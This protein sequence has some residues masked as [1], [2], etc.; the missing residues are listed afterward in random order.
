[1]GELKP[2]GSEKLAGDAKLRRILELTYYNSSDDTVKPSE[3]IKESTT[4]VYGIVKEKDGYYVK[5]GLD[6]NSLDYIGGLYMK[7]KNKFPS[8]GEALKKC[9]FLIEQENLQEATK[10]ILKQPKPVSQAEAPAPVPT[11]ELPPPPAAPEGDVPPPA[12]EDNLPPLPDETSDETP[13][14][15]VQNYLKIIQKMTGKLTQKLSTYQDKLE[16]KDI[17]YVLNMVLAAVDLDKL[18]ETDKEEILSKLE[19]EEDEGEESPD[20]GVPNDQTPIPAEEGEM[21]EADGVPAIAGSSVVDG[22]S[23][24][25]ELINNPFDDDDFT[26][27]DDDDEDE[28]FT[29]GPEDYKAA[30]AAHHDIEKES[31]VKLDDEGNVVSDDEIDI[32]SE[33]KSPEDDDE[34]VDEFMSGESVEPS[35]EEEK[36]KELD[37]DELTNA[38]NGSVRETLGKY[39]SE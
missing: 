28:T 36:V 31:G 26:P 23:A 12:P 27:S 21:E 37:I 9:D 3:V 6:E 38:I 34:E 14:D 1:M 33:L 22:M 39:F 18:E 35:T 15:D 19:D 13:E 5:R 20:M 2:I 11:N 24:L 30:K 16:S 29:I 4:G 7:N 17:K 10:Y 25:E 32:D 8:Y